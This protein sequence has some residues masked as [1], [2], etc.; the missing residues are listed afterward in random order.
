MIFNN[1]TTEPEKKDAK[2]Y[3][4]NPVRNRKNIVVMN[5]IMQQ[6]VIV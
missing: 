5:V 6:W 1:A 2:V 4:D 3:T